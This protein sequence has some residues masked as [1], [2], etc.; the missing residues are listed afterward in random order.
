MR[1]VANSLQ[2]KKFQRDKRIFC[3]GDNSDDFFVVV[4]GQ[5]AVLNPKPIVAEYQKSNTFADKVIG[6]REKYVAQA[7]EERTFITKTQQQIVEKNETLEIKE[8]QA[9]ARRKRA[10]ETNETYRL[11]DQML[12]LEPNQTVIEVKQRN[13]LYQYE[14][15]YNDRLKNP[16]S[17]QKPSES[18]R[19]S[20]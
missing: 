3:A 5:V 7:I 19:P 1:L 14:K 17:I 2:V 11:F 15:E 10:M 4:R 13:P 8:E 18:V 12:G 9:K 16:K 20:I 6:V